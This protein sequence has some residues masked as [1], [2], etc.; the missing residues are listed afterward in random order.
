MKSFKV[1]VMSSKALNYFDDRFGLLFTYSIFSKEGGTSTNSL[2]IQVTGLVKKSNGLSFNN[3]SK[4]TETK[5]LPIV[6]MII[7][8]RLNSGNLETY[9]TECISYKNYPNIILLDVSKIDVS[10]FREYTIE[11]D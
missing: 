8:E 1:N 5:L 9:I 2:E 11:I 6:R 3:D 4:D 10:E 7:T